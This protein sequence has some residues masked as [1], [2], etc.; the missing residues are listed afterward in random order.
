MMLAYYKKYVLN[1]TPN[2][3]KKSKKDKVHAK[4][5]KNELPIE[6]DKPAAGSI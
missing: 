2:H 6:A 4:K 3:N 1:P 5:N